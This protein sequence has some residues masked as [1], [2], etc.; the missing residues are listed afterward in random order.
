[1]G[2]RPFIKMSIASARTHGEEERRR[3]RG[4][5]ERESVGRGRRRRSKGPAS[6]GWREVETLFFFSFLFLRAELL[7]TNRASDPETVRPTGKPQESSSSFYQ[8]GLMTAVIITGNIKIIR[9]RL[10]L[11]RFNYL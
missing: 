3:R 5:R 11:S 10:S 4:E 6:F 1:M 2:T 8:G 9:R 7:C